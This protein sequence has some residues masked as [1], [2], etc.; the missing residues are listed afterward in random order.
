[1]NDEDTQLPLMALPPAQQVERVLVERGEH[2]G[3]ML[4]SKDPERYYLVVK[5][6]SEGFGQIKI[7]ELLNMS[8]HTVRAVLDVELP[9]KDAGA[10]ETSDLVRRA[11]QVRR[12]YLEGLQEDV[13]ERSRR[14]AINPRDKAVVFGILSER[15]QEI[16]AGAIQPGTEQGEAVPAA[17]EF[18][19]WMKRGA[20]K[21]EA[22][23]ELTEGTQPE[24]DARALR[25]DAAEGGKRDGIEPG[26]GGGDPKAEP[27]RG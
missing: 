20:L 4:K 19:E 8:V 24:G 6:H 9:Q 5:L 10:R 23:K 2:T 12:L 13:E 18:R 3:T 22:S 17:D 7:S 25:D 26:E 16:E 14:R 21:T 1:M 15:L 11:K 27:V